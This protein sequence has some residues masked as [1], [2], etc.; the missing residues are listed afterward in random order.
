MRSV[1]EECLDKVIILNARHL[2]RVLTEYVAHYNGRRPHQSLAQDSPCGL[3][4][5]PH[6]GPIRCRHVL[7]GIIRDYYREAA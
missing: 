5:R 2:R 7:G 3:R 1:R 4:P 6:E